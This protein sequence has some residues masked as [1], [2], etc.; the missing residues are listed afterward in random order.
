METEIDIIRSGQENPTRF[1]REDIADF[2]YTNLDQYGD[3]KEAIMACIAYAYG[4]ASGQNGFILLAHRDGE[5]LGAAIVNDTNMKGYIP[6]HILVYLAVR[7]DTRG[8][9]LGKRLMERTIAESPGD[10]ALHVEPD[11]PARHL[12]AKY[13]FDNKYLEMRLAKQEN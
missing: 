12:Y 11:N 4:D 7:S 2:L 6:E 9:G 10:I 1:S 13:G 3:T 5:I 8:Q